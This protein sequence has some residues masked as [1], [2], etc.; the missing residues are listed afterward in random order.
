MWNNLKR[1]FGL[2]RRPKLRTRLTESLESR[3]LLSAAVQSLVPF[4]L[5]Q[6]QPGRVSYAEGRKTTVVSAS[7]QVGEHMLLLPFLQGDKFALSQNRGGTFALEQNRVIIARATSFRPGSRHSVQITTT[8]AN[9]QKE[10]STLELIIPD[11]VQTV[12]VD[13]N[14]EA[15]QVIDQLPRPYQR[16]GVQFRELAGDYKRP[17]GPVAPPGAITI[18]AFWIET[19]E[20]IP[21]PIQIGP[22]GQILANPSTSVLVRGHDVRFDYEH[23][24]PL[25]TGQTVYE[26]RHPNGQSSVL[27]VQV[28]L[29]DVKEPTEIT[30]QEIYHFSDQDMPVYTWPRDR[31]PCANQELRIIGGILQPWVEIVDTGEVSSHRFRIRITDPERLMNTPVYTDDGELDLIVALYE[32]GQQVDTARIVFRYAWVNPTSP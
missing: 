22:R 15:G 29:R 1:F 4:D 7:P 10:V 8:H 16:K 3:E 30:D 6:A 17:M 9:G 25:G 31:Q 23:S 2:A 24:N 21:Q 12:T 28:V 14:P 20:G 32:D 13:E 11:H 26:V 18:Q 27:M 19:F 5:G